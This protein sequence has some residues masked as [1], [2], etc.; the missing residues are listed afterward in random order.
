[1]P[2]SGKASVTF[3]DYDGEITTTSVNVLALSAANYD[4]QATLRTAF[5]AA[6]VAMTIGELQRSE[7]GNVSLQSI[8]PA[9]DVQAQREKKWLVDYH[10]ATSLKRYSFEIGTA[11]LDQ[12]DPNDRAHAEIGDAGIVDA[13]VTAAEAY[14]LS[15]T[16]GAIVVDEITFVGRRN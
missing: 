8:T 16:G 3:A 6:M 11:D 15:P 10:D 5:V 9:S 4:A 7:Y 1:M 2:V 12:L 14:L 13:F